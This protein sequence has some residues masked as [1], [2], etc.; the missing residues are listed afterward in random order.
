[1]LNSFGGSSKAKSISGRLSSLSLT[2]G[3]S[4]GSGLT[5]D[6]TV[7]GGAKIKKRLCVDGSTS[8]NELNVKG[9]VNIEKQMCVHGD[10]NNK[11]IEITNIFSF[12][13]G[14]VEIP[15]VNYVPN[16]VQIIKQPCFGNIQSVNVITGNITYASNYIDPYLDIFQYTI[17]DDCNIVRTVN[18][19]VCKRGISAI[20]PMLN[21]ACHTV[22][23]FSTG[24]GPSNYDLTPSGVAG[25]NPIDWST[26]T[27][28]NLTTYR[29]DDAC[30]AINCNTMN[31][32]YGTTNSV[33][34][35]PPNITSLTSNSITITWPSLNPNPN[36]LITITHNGAGIITYTQN[37][38]YYNGNFAYK[39]GMQVSDVNSNVSN[40]AMFQW[41]VFSGC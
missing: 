1:M 8:L 30:N 38:N 25:T 26:L 5:P 31:I 10:L 16:T 40:T 39:I 41:L 37:Y 20:P 35:S 7:S 3:V 23:S 33:D 21:N 18:Q 4:C 2:G 34:Y 14:Q 17:V 28:L 13:S 27:F 32:P 19:F 11:A 6:L 22:Q 24:T 29:D 12:E 15:P 36:L 9:N